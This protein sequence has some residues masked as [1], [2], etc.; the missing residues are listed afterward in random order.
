MRKVT[1]HFPRKLQFPTI[2]GSTSLLFFVVGRRKNIAGISENV[3]IKIR[4]R[5]IDTSDSRYIL[6][7]DLDSYLRKNKF[8][9]DACLI[10]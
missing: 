7:D 8:K 3:S 6:A 4:R 5:F 1:F 10:R 2:F 9:L